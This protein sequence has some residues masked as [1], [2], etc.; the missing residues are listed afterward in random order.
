MKIF[1][2]DEDFICESESLFTKLIVR[3]SMG[4]LERKKIKLGIKRR[5]QN[6]E[7]MVILFLMP[8]MLLLVLFLVVPL[9]A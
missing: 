5:K 4:M 2:T 6:E 9:F 8:G 1:I 7:D 3:E